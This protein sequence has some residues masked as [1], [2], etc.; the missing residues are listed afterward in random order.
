MKAVWLS[1]NYYLDPAVMSLTTD[2]ERLLTR[3]YALAGTAGHEGFL[4]FV[5]LPLTGIK[6][7]KSRARELV[8]YGLWIER[9]TGWEFRDQRPLERDHIPIAT[10][11][12]VFA[13][14]G[15]QCVHC[16][17]TED[18]SL[19]HIYPWSRGGEDTVDN[20]RVLCRPCNSRKGARV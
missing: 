10:R 17:A 20:L 13:R 18:L 14:D 9:D 8:A 7:A 12:A 16:G 3:G 15:H 6:R 1:S 2:A 5:L 4:P 11:R 19:D